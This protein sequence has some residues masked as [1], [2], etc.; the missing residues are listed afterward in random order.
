MQKFT[1]SRIDEIHESFADVALAAN[2]H[3]VCT[4]KEQDGHGAGPYSRVIVRISVDGGYTW[5]QRR[6]IHAIEDRI[7]G[8]L[9]CSRI[10][11]LKDDSILL[12]ADWIPPGVGEDDEGAQI[13]A[14]RSY[15]NGETWVGP[16]KT[17]VR[18]G[19]VPSIRQL[20]NGDILIGLSV[21]SNNPRREHQVL[22]RSTNN[23]KTWQGPTVVCKHPDFILSEGDFVEL[24]DGV[25]I[26]YMREDM[27]EVGTGVKA[28]SKDGGHTWEGPFR[29][30]VVA[31]NG[32]PSAG[33]LRSGEVAVVYRVEGWGMQGFLALYVES[34]KA[35]A[36][37]MPLTGPYNLG[38]LNTHYPSRLFPIDCDR[39]IASDYG[40]SGW[41]QLPDGD[42]YAVQYIVDDAPKAQIRGYRIQRSDWLLFPEGELAWEAAQGNFPQRAQ[43]RAQEQ[44][45]KNMTGLKNQP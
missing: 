33:L 11:K 19:I 45:R 41:V 42:I 8:W 9:N 25:I 37:P 21:V 32:R 12:V 29:T 34:Q 7:A 14:W 5:G 43:Q 17:S 38:Y 39:S 15:D 26:C 27:R 44:L 24:N 22:Y 3:L 10:L 1:I 6:V 30:A 28:I 35:A 2:G 36:H 13:W 23:G 4:Y 20:R 31:N 16:D 18:G 40:Y